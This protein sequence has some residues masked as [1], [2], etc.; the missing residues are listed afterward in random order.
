MRNVRPTVSKDK[1]TPQ[2]G[3]G[4]GKAGAKAF[5]S[6]KSQNQYQINGLHK[7]GEKKSLK[8]RNKKN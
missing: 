3:H 4:D 1:E 8:M 7:V 5:L 2:F 6:P